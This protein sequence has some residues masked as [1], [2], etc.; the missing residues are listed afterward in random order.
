MISEGCSVTVISFRYGDSHD[1]RYRT[2]APATRCFIRSA[3]RVSLT[4]SSC[5]PP[6]CL[7]SFSCFASFSCAVFQS[8]RNSRL[9]T[10]VSCFLGCRSLL[11]FDLFY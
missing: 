1:Q 5:T 2:D 4:G 8:T 3:T 11:L 9:E 10:L 7:T 6:S